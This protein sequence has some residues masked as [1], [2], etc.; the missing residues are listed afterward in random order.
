[1]SLVGRTVRSFATIGPRRT[2]RLVADRLR[3]RRS[4]SSDVQVPRRIFLEI[5]WTAAPAWRTHPRSVIAP[6][7]HVAWITSPPSPSSGGHQ[8]IFR[9]I[10]AMEDAGYTCT[11]Y[12]WDWRG[13]RVDGTALRAMLEPLSGY[14]NL[15][16]DFVTYDGAVDPSC[17]AIIA[18]AWETAYPAYLDPSQARRFYFVQDFEPWFYPAGPNGLLA[19][20]TYRFGFHGLTAGAWLAHH[21]SDSFDM[22]ADHF[23]FSADTSH[24]HVTR[25]APRGG[26]FFY[27]RPETPR[28]AY[29]LGVR[30]LERVHELAPDVP[31]HFA[32]SAQRA[33]NLRFPVVDHGAVDLA[34]LTDIYNSCSAALVLSL[35]NM[36]LLPL[37][38]VASGVTPIVNDAPH[39]RMVS[40]NPHIRYEPLVAERMA[41]ALIEEATR[42]R[43]RA[44]LDAMT[45]SVAGSTWADSGRQFV[46]HVERALRSELPTEV[47]GQ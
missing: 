6:R 4:S 43:T 10:K 13:S 17:D 40:E 23:D 46:E 7:P 3:S 12:F 11:V 41:T 29:E 44:E 47:S 30:I 16:A 18:T 35:S 20:N 27:S 33:T 36:S 31:L 15:A 38:L 14:P 28:R 32:G 25:D 5:D 22:A 45:A 34:E 26:I 24:Y 2:A 9:F 39:N 8:N 19:E 37:E 42:T 1:M 21:L